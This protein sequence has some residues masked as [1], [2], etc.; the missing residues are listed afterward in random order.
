MAVAEGS[1][2]LAWA[3]NPRCSGSGTRLLVG[4]ETARRSFVEQR[5][6]QRRTIIRSP[7]QHGGVSTLVLQPL[8]TQRLLGV[9]FGTGRSPLSSPPVRPRRVPAGVP[10]WQFSS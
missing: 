10:A 7:V 1:R 4:G 9:K 5:A 3:E 6:R 2:A 8:P